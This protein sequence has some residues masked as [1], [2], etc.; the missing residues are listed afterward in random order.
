MTEY[1]ET[2][3]CPDCNILKPVNDFYKT[4]RGL[5]S[6]CKECCARQYREK[7][8]IEKAEELPGEEWRAITGYGGRYSVSNLGRVRR[9]LAGFGT[10]QGRILKT[11]AHGRCGRYRRVNLETA[12]V[13]VHRLVAD[14]FLVPDEA[15][16][17]VNHI[18]G[19]P[20]DNR[21]V[22]LEYVTHKENMEHAAATLRAFKKKLDAA[23]VVKIRALNAEGF[24]NKEIGRM[25]GINGSTV[26]RVVSRRIWTHVE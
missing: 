4:Q 7:H 5:Y 21:A 9:E 16:P 24:S 19:N 22:N 20:S 1:S 14:A 2:K 25:V 6:Y 26:S 18:N 13:Y 3:T 10:Y 12:M 17:H 15:R 23:L 11:S 8:P